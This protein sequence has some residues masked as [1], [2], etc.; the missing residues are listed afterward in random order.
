M[1]SNISVG[2]FGKEGVTI[3]TDTQGPFALR[4]EI[5]RLFGL[6]LSQVR[7]VVPSVGGGYGG[8]KGLVPSV[9]A[10][11]LSRI[12]QRPVRVAFSAEENFKSICQ[13]R[14]KVVIQTG[15]KKD[16]IFLARRCHVYLNAGAYVNTTPSVAEKAGY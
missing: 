16:G 7:V 1:E 12:A 4:Q 2:N 3:W 10:L 9:I 13:P 11:A 5:A 14:A 15:V 8:A 6:T